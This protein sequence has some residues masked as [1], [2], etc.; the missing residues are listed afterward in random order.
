MEHPESK[1]VTGIQVVPVGTL[2][3]HHP[4]SPRA[5]L[6]PRLSARSLC[7]QV[8]D[9]AISLKMHGAFHL[10]QHQRAVSSSEN[11]PADLRYV[12]QSQ[13][14]IM[15]SLSGREEGNNFPRFLTFL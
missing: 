2:H 10:P 11:S 1:A 12:L 4:V 7:R 6:T 5:Q 8:L 13:G 14:K 9:T 3:T 15:L